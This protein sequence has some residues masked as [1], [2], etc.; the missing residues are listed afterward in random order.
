MH[1]PRKIDIQEVK[2][3]LD[4]FRIHIASARTLDS[5]QRKTLSRTGSV[6][7][8]Q[9]RYLIEAEWKVVYRGE[10]LDEAVRLYNGLS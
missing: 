1:D 7:L 6:F 5:T 10:D 9:R 2:R 3:F 4:S 8:V